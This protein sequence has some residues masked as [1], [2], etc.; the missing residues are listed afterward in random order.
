VRP[1]LPTPWELAFELLFIQNE[2]VQEETVQ[3]LLVRSGAAIGLGTYRGVY[4]KFVV[5]KWE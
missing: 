5:V 4:G 3:N 1:V 2:E